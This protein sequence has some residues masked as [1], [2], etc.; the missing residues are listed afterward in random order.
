M[1]VSTTWTSEEVPITLYV[2]FKLSC[3]IYYTVVPALCAV[4]FS[5]FYI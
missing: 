3:I 4:F 5:E 1:V 2:V